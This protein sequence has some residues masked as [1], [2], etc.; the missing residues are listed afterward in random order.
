MSAFST[1]VFD[2]GKSFRHDGNQKADVGQQHDGEGLAT[3]QTRRQQG[4]GRAEPGDGKV[5]PHLG[6]LA[7]Q[8]GA[9]RL[10]AL[11]HPGDLA[12]F[13]AHA[14]ADHHARAPP[15]HD[16][17]AQVHQIGAVAQWKPLAGKSLRLFAH[18]L[19]FAGQGRFH[20]TEI[21][22]VDQAEV[23]GHDVAGLDEYDVTGN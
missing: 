4:K 21:H 6:Y 15:M 18:R 7:L 20:D 16:R 3:E 14:G 2:G 12:Q 10:H 9:A 13:G 5:F 22:A 11:D 23:G 1:L 19:R 17:S 8:R